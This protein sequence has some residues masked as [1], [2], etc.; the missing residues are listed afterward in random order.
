GLTTLS[1][2]PT[3]SWPRTRATQAA[4]CGSSNQ[5]AA[6]KHWTARFT[7]CTP[8]DHS[9]RTCSKTMSGTR[10]SSKSCSRTYSAA[11]KNPLP[12]YLH[13]QQKQHAVA[14]LAAAEF[15]QETTMP[16]AESRLA[17]V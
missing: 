10:S 14:V 11:Q 4:W 16:T 8:L 6:T 1:S 5:A 2:S 17:A 9:K 12:R 3:K 15:N 13:A 7:P